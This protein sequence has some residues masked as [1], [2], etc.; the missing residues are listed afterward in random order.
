[1]CCTHSLKTM[2]KA[3]ANSVSTMGL[4]LI[5]SEFCSGPHRNTVPEASSIKRVF[6]FMGS[7]DPI[8]HLSKAHQWIS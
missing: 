5:D 8:N 4:F 7:S 6:V 3:A 1:M 2:I